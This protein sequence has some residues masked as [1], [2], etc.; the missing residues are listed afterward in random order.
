MVVEDKSTT[1]KA[2]VNEL[3][4][5]VNKLTDDSSILSSVNS[6]GDTMSNEDVL[7]DLKQIN[8][9]YDEIKKEIN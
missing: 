3:V 1:L 9:V 6:I 8:K 4:N 5:L 2:I 7:I